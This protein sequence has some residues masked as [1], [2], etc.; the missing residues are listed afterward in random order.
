M[1][2]LK[3]TFG[4]CTVLLGLCSSAWGADYTVINTNNTGVGSLRQAILDANVNL[5]L[6]RIKFEIPGG[7]VK[8]IRLTTALPTNSGP[9]EIDGFTQPGSSP[10]T[11]PDADN[12]VRLIE[13]DGGNSAFDGLVLGGGNSTLRGL[14]LRRFN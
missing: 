2:S 6:G 13:L 12:G 11:L 5:G 4:V 10:N 8:V 1:L 14:S 9:V 3:S 7:G